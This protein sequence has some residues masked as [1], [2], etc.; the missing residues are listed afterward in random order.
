MRPV[1]VTAIAILT[2]L[3]ASLYALGGLMLI[4]VGHLSARL[5]SAIAT[6]SFL[7]RM[8]SGLGKTLGIGALAI[9]LGFVI[10]GIGLWQ[11]KNWARVAILILAA[12]WLLSALVG[13]ARYPTPFHIVR[14]LVDIG[15]LVYLSLPKVRRLFVPA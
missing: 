15:I 5:V 6:D 1:G 12:I 4:G 3:R 13:V 10:V 14:V 11:L 2:W 7:E 9:A 8:V